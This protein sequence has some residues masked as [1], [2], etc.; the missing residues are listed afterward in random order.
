MK[1]I[2]KSLLYESDDASKLDKNF[3]HKSGIDFDIIDIR[4]KRVKGNIGE[5]KEK[6]KDYFKGFAAFEKGTNNFA[7]FIRVWPNWVL[8]EKYH[9]NLISPVEVKPKYRGY[10][11]GKLLVK[12]SM[13]KYN[14][15][16]LMVAKDNEVAIN[17]YKKLGFYIDKD[18]KWKNEDYYIMIMN[19]VK[20]VKLTNKVNESTNNNELSNLIDICKQLSTYEYILVDE[21]K[22]IEYNTARINWDNHRTLSSSD[23]V[24]CHGGIC[25]DYVNYEVTKVKSKFKTFFTGFIKNN[26][27]KA[28]HTYLLAYIDNYVYWLE[29]SWKPHIGIYK[30]N[31]EDEALSYIV[32][33]LRRDNMEDFTVEYKPNSSLVGISINDF[34]GKMIDLPDYKYKTMKNPKCENIYKIKLDNNGNIIE[35]KSKFLNE[36]SKIK[37]VTFSNSFKDVKNIADSLTKEE[38]SHICNGTFKNSPFVKYRRVV[39]INKDPAA[40]IDVY[41]IPKEMNK[42]EAAIVCAC[43]RKY[44]GQGLIRTCYEGLEAAVYKQ[45]IRKL[46]WETTKTNKAS[47]HLAISL[48]F[49]K[50]EDINNDDDNYVKIIYMAELTNEIV[51][52]MSGTIGA[53]LPTHNYIMPVTPIPAPTPY[54]SDPENYYIVTHPKNNKLTYSITKDP[55]QYSLYSVDP[56]EKGFYKVFKSDKGKIDKRYLTFKIKDKQKA[57]ELYESL[58]EIYN[59]NLTFTENGLRSDQYPDFIYSYLTDGSIIKTYDQILFDN[60]FELVSD[61]DTSVNEMSDNIYNYLKNGVSNIDTLQEQIKE[62][63]GIIYE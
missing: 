34:I 36:S 44:R 26:K 27:V 4:D 30:F 41:S 43:K 14:A 40:F 50:G 19:S 5:V 31:S 52:D 38:L 47:S 59:R 6:Y 55:L 11:L 56:Q 35:E 46:Y 8:E 63:E 33:I 53:A 24:K 21:N 28:T 37:S 18:K 16:M 3:K 23:F 48:G 20:V 1:N 61:F 39:L 15:N 12:E 25:Y 10:G 60:R 58:E 29:C 57:K 32:N 13:E 9:G 7:G 51:E 62:L 22:K 17:M 2:N 49:S 45:G 54:E 42:D